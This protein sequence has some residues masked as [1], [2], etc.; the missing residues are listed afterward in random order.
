M[1]VSSLDNL[2]ALL[3]HA[4]ALLV[5]M[6]AVAPC[7]SSDLTFLEMHQHGV[8]GVTDLAHP[9]ECVV[10]Q[11]GTSVYVA[12]NASDSVV[13][14]ARDAVTGR[15][16]FTGSSVDGVG[17]V[18]GLDNCAGVAVSP[19]GEHVYAVGQTDDAVAVF[20]RDP[21]TGALT[22][23]ESHVDGVAGVDGLDRAIHVM[24]SPDGAN[25][26]VASINDDAVAV[27]GRDAVDGRLTFIE[28]H[29]HNVG[30]VSGMDPPNDLAMDSQGD[31]VYVAGTW[32][33]AVAVFSRDGTTGAL[34]YA[35]RFTAADINGCVGVA[36]TPDDGSVIATSLLGDSV[37]VFDRDPVSGLLTHDTTFTDGVGGVT[38]IVGAEG[39]VVDPG[40]LFVSVV[41]EY[42]DSV[43]VFRR[44]P[45]GG[46]LVFA[47]AELDGV[48]GVDGLDGPISGCV[49]PT[50][51]SVYVVSWDDDAIVAFRPALL[52]DGFESGGTTRWSSATP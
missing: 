51:R 44:D 11:D 21:A 9:Y 22:W 27:F 24:V 12:A 33:Q 40:G 37:V 20:A 13:H 31:H 8:G 52:A 42:S 41:G 14:F 43:A 6:A 28:A 17:G 38:G 4:A 50:G 10:S 32:S 23:V 48:A 26:Y 30:G 7:Q 25:V 3:P 5:V 36:V 35:D 49:D 2:T 16:T 19:G 46:G 45:V 39:I 18:D 47:G 29:F 15:L 34:T 1:R